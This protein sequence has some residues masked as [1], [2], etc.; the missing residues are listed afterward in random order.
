VNK[1]KFKLKGWMVGGLVGL[2]ISI[3]GLFP[4][5]AYLIEHFCR[6]NLINYIISLPLMLSCKISL[7]NLRTHEVSLIVIHMLFYVLTF[8][9]L[10]SFMSRFKK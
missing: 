4:V 3:I 10:G 1:K 7:F 5:M 9:M 8:S 2:V 6:H